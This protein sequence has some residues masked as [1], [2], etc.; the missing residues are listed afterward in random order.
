MAAFIATAAAAIVTALLGM[1]SYLYQKRTD[2]R[3]ALGEQQQQAYGLYITSYYD[4]TITEEN[5]E[6]ASK[7]LTTYRR[8]YYA[9]FPIASDG[10]LK[11][12]TAFH[13]YAIEGSF[14]WDKEEDRVKFTALWTRLVLELRKDVNVKSE[15]SDEWLAK[16]V[17]WGSFREEPSATLSPQKRD[18]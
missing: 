6:E 2:H 7:A 8:A 9:L 3:V 14:V 12:A 5:N 1:A 10:F 17:P 18:A 13:A 16:H 4:W 11:T 15:L